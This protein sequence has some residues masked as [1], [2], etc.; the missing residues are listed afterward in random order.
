MVANEPVV[1]PKPPRDP[2]QP[3]ELRFNF[4]GAGWREVLGWLAEESGMALHVGDVPAGTFSY[5]DPDPFTTDEAIARLNLFLIPEGYAIVRRAKL[6]SVIALGEPRSLQ[7]LDALAMLTPIEE[8]DR[9]GD[10]EVVKCII[11]LG[12]I[13]AT[14][15]TAELQPLTFITTPDRTN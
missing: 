13:I 4:S 6:L 5:T 15:A 1:A 14:E 8:L 2:S 12:E 7:Q 9:R 10:H 3:V 11:P